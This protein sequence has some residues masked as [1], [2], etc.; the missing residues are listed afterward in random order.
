MSNARPPFGASAPSTTV[1]RRLDVV[2]LHVV[3]HEL[4]DDLRVRVLRGVGTE[5]GESLDDPRQLAFR[6]HDVAGLDVV[7]RQLGRRLEEQRAP[8]V[9]GPPA[10]V[11]RIEE[12]VAEELELELIEAVLVEDRPQLAERLRLEHVLEVGMPDAD[13][14]EPDPRGLLAALAEAEEAPL[15]PEVHL[16][17]PGGGPVEADEVVAA[18]HSPRNLTCAASV[19]NNLGNGIAGQLSSDRSPR[20]EAFHRGRLRDRWCRIC[21]LRPRRASERGS[22][23]QRAAAGGGPARHGGRAPRAGHVPARLQVQ[24]R[25]GS[26]RRRRAWP[27]RAPALLPARPRDRR[28]ELDQRDDLPARQPHRLRRLGCERRGWLVVRR[29]A[30]VLQAL[31][32]QRARRERVPRRGRAPRGVRQPLDDA[33]HRGAA[34]GCR[35]GGLRAHRRPERRPAGGRLSLPAHAAQRHAVQRGRRLPPS[36]GEQAEP[37]GEVRRVRRADR[38]RGRPRRRR[39]AR[40]ERRARDGP[41]RA[42]GDRLRRHVPVTGAA[43][44]L[45]DR[46]GGRPRDLRNPRAAGPPG[47]REPPG[48]LHGQRQLPHRPAGALRD[49]HAGELRAPRMPRVA[50]R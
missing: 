2:H 37:R 29:G 10:L 25:L 18:A 34:R 14:P 38:L 23:R 44:A 46:P 11:T 28:L 8:F 17:R 19:A 27:R 36:G 43:D 20:Q 6:A 13:A 31:G 42:R 16:D 32:G 1:E 4:V 49:L 15:A 5:L 24:P 21:G 12:P 26:V 39:R 50:G 40:P 35:V 7:R 22:R 9:G 45:G 3:R 47:R 30:P 48:P 41:G 33:V